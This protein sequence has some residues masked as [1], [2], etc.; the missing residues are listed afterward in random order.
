YGVRAPHTLL[1]GTGDAPGAP[2]NRRPVQPG[3]PR[4]SGRALHRRP[5]PNPPPV[6]GTHRRRLRAIVDRENR[7]S[8]DRHRGPEKDVS[9]A[10]PATAA[11]AGR[12]P[13][14]AGAILDAEPPRRARLIS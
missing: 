9:P 7:C 14:R 12:A 5:V 1:H 2:R 3:G 11:L 10:T 13:D 4:R 6:P 8:R